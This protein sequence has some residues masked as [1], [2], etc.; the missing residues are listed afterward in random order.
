MNPS[1]ECILGTE[2]I[3]LETPCIII[4]KEG[5]KEDPSDGCSYSNSK[6]S[7]SS[8]SSILTL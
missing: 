6:S 5:I 3:K 4:S 7:S 1:M 2:S 8:I